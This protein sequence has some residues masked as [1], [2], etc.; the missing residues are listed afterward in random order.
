M[1]EKIEEKKEDWALKQL[2]KIVGNPH[3]NSI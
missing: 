3:K 2:K 1:E